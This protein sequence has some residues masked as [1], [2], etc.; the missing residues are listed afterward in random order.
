[1]EELSHVNTHPYRNRNLFTPNGVDQSL[2]EYS[3]FGPNFWFP[4][5]WSILPALVL[6]I[7]SFHPDDG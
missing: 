2:R 1:M 6:R 7:S 4:F 5:L 3:V